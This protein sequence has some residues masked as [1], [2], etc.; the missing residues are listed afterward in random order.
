DWIRAGELVF[1]APRGYQPLS[2]SPLRD[3]EFYKTTNVPLA[4]D[5]I[6]AHGRYVIRKKGIVEI[7]ANACADCHTRVLPD[8]SIVQG[9]QGNFP[10]LGKNVAFRLRRQAVK[11]D[12]RGKE[13]SLAQLRTQARVRHG[14][15][16][17]QPDPAEDFITFDEMVGAY[18]A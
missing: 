5:G 6:V 4:K 7:G 10:T 11:L 12:E 1:D 8:G 9:A 3:P 18:G 15:P 14:A 16:W 2:N 17:I 13:E